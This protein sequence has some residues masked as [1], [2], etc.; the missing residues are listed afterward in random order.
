ME[1]TLG[2]CDTVWSLCLVL[3]WGYVRLIGYKFF[4]FATV[5]CINFALDILKVAYIIIWLKHVWLVLTR[6]VLIP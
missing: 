4:Q 6:L 5:V 1:L 3:L 2:W